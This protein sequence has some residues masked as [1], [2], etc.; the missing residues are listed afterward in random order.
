MRY[1]DLLRKVLN[2]GHEELNQRTGLKTTRLIGAIVD[3]EKDEGIFSPRKVSARVAAAEAAWML[4]GDQ[5][6]AWISRHTKIWSKFEDED[7]PGFISTAYG[8]RLR[9]AFG[10]DQIKEAIDIL[11]KDPSTRQCLL[12]NW[13]PRVDGLMNQGKSKNVPCPFSFQLLV[14]AGQGFIVVY[15]RSADFVIGIPYDL[16]YYYI[17]GQA[18]FNSAGYPFAGVRIMIGDTHIYENHYELVVRMLG[19][20]LPRHPHYL[21]HDWTVEGILQAPDDF[22][23]NFAEVYKGVDWPMTDRLEAAQ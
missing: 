11:K 1:M 18:L 21:R 3:L 19:Y 13:D 8:Y 14:G 4:M 22:V 15:Q 12:L 2:E 16:M 7:L 6:T 5:S 10:R 17:L 9:H 23:S 20:A